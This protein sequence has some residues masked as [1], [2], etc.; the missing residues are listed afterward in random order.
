MRLSDKGVKNLPSQVKIQADTI[1]FSQLQNAATANE[2]MAKLY[3]GA[4]KSAKLQH[5]T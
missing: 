2:L 1:N 5:Q 4:V 3:M